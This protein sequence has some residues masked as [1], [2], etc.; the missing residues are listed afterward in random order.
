MK[1]GSRGAATS[2]AAGLLVGCLGVWSCG[3]THKTQLWLGGK[4]MEGPPTIFKC[5]GT[6]GTAWIDLNFPARGGCMTSPP[7]EITYVFL[8]AGNAKKGGNKV[9]LQRTILKVD[10][11]TPIAFA[12][13]RQL[14]ADGGTSD[15]VAAHYSL[16][17]TVGGPCHDKGETTGTDTCRL[18]PP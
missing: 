7:V 1:R 11:D 14:R 16:E 9:F 15:V 10:E 2:V 17:V 13:P 8:D 6:Y 18:E 12:V 3:T 5:R 4:T